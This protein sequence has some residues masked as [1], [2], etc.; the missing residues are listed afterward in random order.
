MPPGAFANTE[1]SITH[2]PVLGHRV[3]A[4]LLLAQGWSRTPCDPGG[5]APVGSTP[6]E[7]HAI[8]GLSP[9]PGSPVNT[10]FRRALAARPRGS[11]CRGQGAS[12]ARAT[13]CRSTA[14]RALRTQSLGTAGTTT[15][16]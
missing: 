1:I 3:P 6:A 7:R 13:S 8:A 15:F 14:G 12:P 5:G 9:R 10:G 11:V 2:S 4:A 16:L